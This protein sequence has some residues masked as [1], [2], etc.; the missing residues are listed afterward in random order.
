MTRTRQIPVG[1]GNSCPSFRACLALIVR[2][3]DTTTDAIQQIVS[4]FG[5]EDEDSGNDGDEDYSDPEDSEL[6]AEAKKSQ[7]S[8]TEYT[9]TE[10]DAILYN[11]GIGAT[12]KETKW[13][14]EGDG[15]FEV[16]PTFGVIPQF[17][18][19]ASIAREYIIAD[20]DKC[21]SGD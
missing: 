20:C 5:N 16:L 18:A 3:L 15:E 19:T 1:S 6:V 11:L 13:T 4:N 12:E 10:R 14:F 21:L 17:A 2:L 7:A 9:Y 8:Q